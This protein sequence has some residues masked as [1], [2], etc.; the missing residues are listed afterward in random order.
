LKLPPGSE[1]NVNP[2][3]KFTI[4]NI[5]KELNKINQNLSASHQKPFPKANLLA[6]YSFQKRFVC[7][8]PNG[9][10][11]GGYAGIVASLID[12]S[13]VRSMVADAYS[14]FGPPCFRVELG[15]YPP[16]APTDPYERV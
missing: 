16:R 14:I 2:I 9:D 8:E 3:H 15:G 13:F 5:A 11:S 7:I 4:A 12:F 6:Q 10:I 1:V